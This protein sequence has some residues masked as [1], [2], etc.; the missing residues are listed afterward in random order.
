MKPENFVYNISYQIS[1]KNKTKP[2]CLSFCYSLY[3]V[4]EFWSQ[5]YSD[6][7]VSRI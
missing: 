7:Q 3:P 6:L 5:T 4:P 2:K 1:R